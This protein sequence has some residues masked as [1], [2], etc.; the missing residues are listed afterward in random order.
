[1]GVLAGVG[2]WVSLT[3]VSGY[4]RALRDRQAMGV[5]EGIRPADQ[6]TEFF[7][8]SATLVREL[9]GERVFP[10]EFIMSFKCGIR[11]PTV[12][13]NFI[14]FLFAFPMFLSLVLLL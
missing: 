3:Y 4:G 13:D 1:M 8:F 11:L 2:V 9:S 7:I 10:V 12:W 14:S 5:W 6:P